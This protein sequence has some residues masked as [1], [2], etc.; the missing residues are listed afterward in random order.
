MSIR[1]LVLVKAG[2]VVGGEVVVKAEGVIGVGDVAVVFEAN[3]VVKKTLVISGVSVVALYL[4]N[5]WTSVMMRA[6]M[7]VIGCGMFSCSD[8]R[9]VYCD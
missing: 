4:A 5:V 2:V 6:E 8:R 1:E 9:S 7:D 3:M